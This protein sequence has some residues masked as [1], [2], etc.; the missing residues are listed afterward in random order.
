MGCLLQRFI[1][2]LIF[3]IFSFSAFVVV[4]VVLYFCMDLVGYICSQDVIWKNVRTIIT[5]RKIH[6]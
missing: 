2:P 1:V 6:V 4:F 5:I 3:G